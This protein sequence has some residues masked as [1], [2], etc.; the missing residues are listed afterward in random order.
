MKRTATFAQRRRPLTNQRDEPQ[1][2]APEWTVTLADMMSLLLTFFILLLAMSEI[3][4]EQMYQDIAEALRRRFGHELSQTNVTPGPVMPRNARVARNPV[5]DRA[6]Q[7]DLES[8]GQ[9]NRA[10]I[11]ASPR[12]ESPTDKGQAAAAVVVFF[13]PGTVEPTPGSLRK[14]EIFAAEAS[15]KPQRI[16]VRGHA[17]RLPLPSDA[18]YADAWDLAYERARAVLRVLTA[19]GIAE[20][21]I[22]IASSAWHDPLDVGPAPEDVRRNDRAEVYLLRETYYEPTAAAILQGGSVA[23]EPEQ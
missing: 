4:E 9:K 13:K 22:R 3:K 10:P 17:S 16:S 18:P 12:V 23:T 8:G 2:G 5:V 21:R 14:L 20:P 1:G 15:G 19:A 7:R 6:R 11:G